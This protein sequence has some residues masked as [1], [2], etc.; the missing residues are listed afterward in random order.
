MVLKMLFKSA[1]DLKNKMSD[2]DYYIHNPKR[3]TIEKHVAQSRHVLY[4]V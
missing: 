2:V 1:L 4:I 3:T